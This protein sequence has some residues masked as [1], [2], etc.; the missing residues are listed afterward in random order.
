M[1]PRF[2][3]EGRAHAWGVA[4]LAAGP[5]FVLLVLA[6]PLIRANAS[7]PWS[8]ILVVPLAVVLGLVI[9]TIPAGLL[10]WAGGWLGAR[11]RVFRH[12]SVWG[13]VGATAGVTLG[14]LADVTRLG[15]VWHGALAGSLIAGI[16]RRLVR[17][18]DPV[19]FPGAV[20]LTRGDDT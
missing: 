15:T 8:L 14:A 13:G 5:T 3:V 10:V 17:W 9:T 7:M 4:A 19:V 6:G 16:A 2:V 20:P 1:Q 12:P 11:W 18:R